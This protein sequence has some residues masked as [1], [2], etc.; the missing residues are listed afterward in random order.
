MFYYQL[1]K[2]ACKVNVC[3]VNILLLQR[4]KQVFFL[5]RFTLKTSKKGQSI[6]VHPNVIVGHEKMMI[7]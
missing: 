4:I 6:W 2:K 5:C 7:L 1:Q 3:R